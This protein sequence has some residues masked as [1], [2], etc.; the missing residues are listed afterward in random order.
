MFRE[1]PKLQRLTLVTSE[2][3]LQRYDRSNFAATARQL[4]GELEEEKA[5]KILD[6]AVANKHPRLSDEPGV[7]YKAHKALVGNSVD[8][9]KK[10][11]DII[12]GDGNKKIRRW[13]GYTA[14][15]LGAVAIGGILGIPNL[16]KT[17]FGR[18]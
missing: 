4:D 8:Y 16:L 1:N 11:H 14:G 9:F 7:M 10:G 18:K 17:R 2:G 5:K 3:G 12:L 15:G 13:L 6:V